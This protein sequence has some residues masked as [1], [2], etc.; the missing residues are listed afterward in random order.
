MNIIEYNNKL[1]YTVTIYNKDNKIREILCMNIMFDTANLNKIGTYSKIYPFA[2]V[3]SNPS[4]IK[5]EGKIN[6][7]SHMRA[8]RKIIG[9]DR[10]LHVQIVSQTCDQMIEEA[11]RLVDKLGDIYIKIPVSEEGLKAIKV[12]KENGYHITA[13]CIYSK[14]QGDMAIL[15]GADYI[16]P[17][18]N[19]MENIGV[20]PRNVIKHFANIIAK[21]SS[22][23]KILAASFKNIR[24]VTD[25]F[26][27]GAD[28]A[29]VDPDLLHNSINA[30]H[31]LKA[32]EQ[33]SED[34]YSIFGQNTSILELKD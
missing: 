30:P 21:C 5:K 15:A 14:I 18:F 29:T 33:F 10:T 24:Q 3:T 20:E 7:F 22:D 32:T 31:I 23:T 17:Y 16:A 4:I 28:Y 34:W 1:Q 11:Y 12:L 9:K 25:S 8:I 27:N 13:T 2:G 6:F 19:R 26:E